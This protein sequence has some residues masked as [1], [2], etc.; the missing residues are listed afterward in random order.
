MSEN[1]CPYCGGMRTEQR[2]ETIYFWEVTKVK[3]PSPQFVKDLNIYVE[4]CVRKVYFPEMIFYICSKCDG[5]W[6]EHPGDR[7]M[8][9]FVSN[10]SAEN[11]DT[12]VRNWEAAKREKG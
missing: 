4:N 6:R 5:I 9:G 1:I 7:E 12:C 3:V 2:F 11:Y 10:I 8:A